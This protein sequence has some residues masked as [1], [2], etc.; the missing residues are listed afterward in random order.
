VA[1]TQVVYR[2][3]DPSAN[4]SVDCTSGP[5]HALVTRP[6]A[7]ECPGR[8]VGLSAGRQSEASTPSRRFPLHRS[9]RSRTCGRRQLLSRPLKWRP[10]GPAKAAC[11]APGVCYWPTSRCRPRPVPASL[12]L[13]DRCVPAGVRDARAGPAAGRLGDEPSGTGRRRPLVSAAA[14][15]VSGGRHFA[16][17][18]RSDRV[19]P[20]IRR[21]AR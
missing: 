4:A 10:A 1:L 14:S 19:S 11:R 2:S 12:R 16:M 5:G 9:M 20:P 15:P 18:P 3:C 13:G 21:C 7:T 6:G 8:R 17:E